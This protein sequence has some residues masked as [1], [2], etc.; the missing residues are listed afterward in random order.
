MR[1]KQ[2]NLGGLVRLRSVRERDS[3][4]GLAAA[5]QEERQAVAKLAD[6]EQLLATL[7]M[8]AVSDL[9]AFRGRQHTI[10]MI[11]E[12]LADTRATL[13]TARQ[14]TAAARERWI[15]DQN[16]LAAVESLVERRVA[17]A[18]AERQRRET[19]DL[20]E[21]AQDLWRRGSLVAVAGGGA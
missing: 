7:P 1:R 15:S 14:L 19:R 12:A 16:R 6:L 21:V 17:A 4:I 2:G 3:R 18:R 20:D 9:A 10:D 13:E 5:L 11:R 8:P